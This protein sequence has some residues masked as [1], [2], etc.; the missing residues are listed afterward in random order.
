M[1]TPD[2]AHQLLVLRQGFVA[3]LPAKLAAL[4]AA[5][6]ASGH[7]PEALAAATTLAHRLRGS[8]GSFGQPAVGV[9]VG[10]IE[11]LLE[12]AAAGLAGPG[13]EE[14][15]A[16]ALSAAAT[17]VAAAIAGSTVNAAEETR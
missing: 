7:D 17:A 10:R 14:D 13:L 12:L 1:T 5:V 16:L 11:E 8:A 15:L 9:A 6:L 4:E 2:L 3:K